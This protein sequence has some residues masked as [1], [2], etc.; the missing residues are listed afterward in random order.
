MICIHKKK[1]YPLKVIIFRI[2]N[3]HCPHKTP[4]RVG[5]SLFVL[6]PSLQK[7]VVV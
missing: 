1:D 4:I 2:F 3:T 7:F 6:S 5:A